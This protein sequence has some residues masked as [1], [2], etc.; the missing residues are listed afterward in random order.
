MK[1]VPSRFAVL[2]FAAGKTFADLRERRWSLGLALRA[3]WSIQSLIN[4]MSSYH[5]LSS[6]FDQVAL[7]LAGLI[8]SQLMG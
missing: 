7:L 3:E 1:R 5:R 8:K 6:Y 4:L 2:V